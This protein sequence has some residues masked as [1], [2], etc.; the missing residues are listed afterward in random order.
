MCSFSNNQKFFSAILSIAL[1]LLCIEGTRAQEGER[2]SISGSVV[3]S[4]SKLPIAYA[5]ITV[6]DAISKK[7]V[8]GTVADSNGTFTVG[9]LPMST[10]KVLI[11]FIGYRQKEVDEIVKL[12]NV[13]HTFTIDTIYLYS[14]G[15]TLQSAVV[16]AKGPI[17]ENK[18]DK[19]V[20]NA[21]NDVTSQG[22]MALDVLRK[23]PQV[24]VDADGNVELQGNANI[25]FL[26]NGKPST[27]FGSSVTDALSA[28]PAS[29]I[30]NIEA[31]TSPSAKYDAQGTG[32][33]INIIL[34]DNK[35][36]GING[37]VNVTTGTRIENGSATLNYRHN[38]LGI[39]ISGGGNLQLLSHSP[40]SLDRLSM[41]TL[42]RTMT[43][44]TQ[45]GYNDYHRNGYDMS[46]S[47]D[48][49]ISKLTSLTGSISGYHFGR[50][51]EGYNTQEQLTKDDISGILISDVNSYRNAYNKFSNN[52][53]ETSLDYT[54]K[55]IREGEILE[56]LYSGSYSRPYFE[57]RQTQSLVGANAP[58][59]GSAS[60]NPAADNEN[61]FSIDYTRPVSD[62]VMITTGAKLY[63]E[64]LHSTA[65]VNT[66]NTTTNDYVKD[67]LQSYA[68]NYHM[69]VYAGYIEGT[70]SLFHM[71]DVRAGARY[72][73]T[74]VRTDF[75]NTVIPNYGNIVPSLILSHKLTKDRQI[76]LAYSH[77]IER[78]EY[79]E[80]NPFLNFADPY[81]ITTG[82]PLLRPEIGDN[83]E[84]GYSQTFAKGGNIYVSLIERINSQDHKP[85]TAFYPTYKIGDSV[86]QNVSVTN[87]QNIGR[88]YNS[89]I[90]VNASLPIKK[91]SIR[92]NMILMH[93]YLVTDIDNIGNV[94]GGLRLRVSLNV[95]YE[96]PRDLVMEAFEN[97]NSANGNIQGRS[98]QF[99]YYT[100]ALRKQFLN[101]KASV[102]FTAT[103]PFNKYIEQVTTIATNNYSSYFE[104]GIVMQSFGIIFTYKFGK[105]EFKGGKEVEMK[106][107]SGGQ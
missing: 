74:A 92:W 2:G 90:I 79:G 45:D 68:L 61:N 34:K 93:R 100:I 88:E 25:R 55:Y 54:R 19:V 50:H 51:T 24:T 11:D 7:T 59:G 72:E 28:I 15:H 9:D 16:T 95:S 104:K 3:D 76:K 17:V 33:I 6:M 106:D 91:L 21:A 44:L 49:S 52:V 75:P 105:L 102:G 29:Q 63:T 70:F 64:H 89:G 82:N 47:F 37:S 69:Q 18:I 23:V 99:F 32:G 13:Q 94:D 101:K 81:N 103:D 35:V 85:F 57:Y 39:N 56:M 84:L 40:F 22:G 83:L 77:R 65:D 14:G 20:Y 80:L 27:M 26:I 73:Y 36:E 87:Q 107:F 31:I 1:L 67:P 4:M 62:K 41:D 98:P 10:Y 8:N 48:W 46:I 42:N 58:F 5:T 38:N 60:T 96:F 53:I 30:K 12:T 43:H 97:Y 71:L 78:A 66:Y 86:Y